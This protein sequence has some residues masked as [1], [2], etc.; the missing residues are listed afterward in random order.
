VAA[1][2]IANRVAGASA[3]T[4]AKNRAVIRWISD[5]L[6]SGFEVN[7]RFGSFDIRTFQL[8]PIVS[9]SGARQCPPTGQ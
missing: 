5:R 8:C 3:S 6:R 2:D 4:A 7:P 9:T 1:N